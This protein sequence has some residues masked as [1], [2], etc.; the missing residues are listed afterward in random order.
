MPGIA[1]VVSLGLDLILECK[2]SAP[3]ATTRRK[4]LDGL[5]QHLTMHGLPNDLTA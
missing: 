3:A 5:S 4:V 1:E 2:P